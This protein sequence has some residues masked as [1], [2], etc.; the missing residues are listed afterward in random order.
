MLNKSTHGFISFAKSKAVSFG[1]RKTSLS[2]ID[3]GSASMHCGNTDL[4][5]RFL[6]NVKPVTIFTKAS[7]SAGKRLLTLVHLVR[8]KY[9]FK[10]N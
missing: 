3:F 2:T 1:S 5:G 6:D 4:I 9:F 10:L 8:Y 7:F